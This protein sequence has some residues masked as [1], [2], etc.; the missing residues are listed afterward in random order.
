MGTEPIAAV[1]ALQSIP[2]GS[3]SQ[4]A[5]DVPNGLATQ[6]MG[7][8]LHPQLVPDSEASQDVPNDLAPQSVRDALRPQSVLEGQ[9][10]QSALNF[11]VDDMT[12]TRANVT[13]RFTYEELE[14]ITDKFKTKIGDGAF[15]PVFKGKLEDG[16]LVAVKRRRENSWQ[17]DKEFLAEVSVFICIIKDFLRYSPKSI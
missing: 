8:A 15:G 17:G 4:F 13:Q 7:D 11:D 1:Q 16:T 3:A 12:T 5:G 2:N 10:S 9:G 6:S 14:V